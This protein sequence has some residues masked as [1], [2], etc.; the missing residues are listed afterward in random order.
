M[1]PRLGPALPIAGAV[2]VAGALAAAI[3]PRLSGG[4]H[5]QAAPPQR[6]Y[7]QPAAMPDWNRQVLVADAKAGE[8]IYLRGGGNV[9]A[10]LTCHGEAGLPEPRAPYPRLAGLSADYIAKQLDDYA[11]GVRENPQMQPIARA[12]SPQQRGQVAVYAAGLAA[13]R[14]A[15]SASELDLHGRTLDE[16]GD[17]EKAL[18]GCGNCHGL[19][20]NG[21][22][23]MLPP[24]AGQP[25]AYLVS[26]L[27]AFR[28]RRRQNDSATVMEGIAMRLSDQDIAAVAR[29]F[30]RLAPTPAEAR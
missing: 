22:G 19:R 4:P 12:L 3:V 20:G 15:L 13:P 23:S 30:S 24:L 25:E 11:T 6:D 28:A 9:T 8:Q 10:C 14:T 26:Q 2:L 16:I 17:N 18:P 21:E 1:M 27:H 7:P 5:Q 29:Y